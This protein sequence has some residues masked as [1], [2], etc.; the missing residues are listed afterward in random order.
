[1]IARRSDHLT[2]EPRERTS[3]QAPVEMSH[4]PASTSMP[5]FP[6]TPARRTSDVSAP[7]TDSHFGIDDVRQP[8]QLVAKIHAALMRL[9]PASRTGITIPKT[10]GIDATSSVCV[11]TAEPATRVMVPETMAVRT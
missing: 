9:K 7:S 2:S 10:T 1:M 4:G 6:V 5:A 11:R 8:A 3:I